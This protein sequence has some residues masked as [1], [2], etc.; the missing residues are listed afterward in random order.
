MK[1][2]R[3]ERRHCRPPAI[4]T[5]KSITKRLVIT[6]I[7]PKGGRS[8]AQ[9]AEKNG[10]KWS[11]ST[12]QQAISRYLAKMTFFTC[13]NP[14]VRAWRGMT[15]TP[16]PLWTLHDNVHLR[17][18]SSFLP[19]RAS[20]ALRVSQPLPTV[21]NS[22]PQPIGNS[23]SLQNF[24]KRTYFLFF[25]SRF[26]CLIWIFLKIAT[27]FCINIISIANLVYWCWKKKIAFFI[28]TVQ[29]VV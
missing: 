15:L 29:K 27:Q 16:T 24:S 19:K 1:V 28:S 3:W 2:S 22:F 17:R 18:W 13:V 25:E 9:L 7:H 10:A 23:N 5:I 21:C 11:T 12:F 20:I 6:R 8:G 14:V 4:K 26:H